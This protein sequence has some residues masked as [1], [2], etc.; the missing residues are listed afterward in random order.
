MKDSTREKRVFSIKNFKILIFLCECTPAKVFVF[1]LYLSNRVCLLFVLYLSYICLI[2]SPPHFPAPR[3]T[4][5]PSF[6]PRLV[7]WFPRATC[8]ELRDH[9][10]RQQLQDRFR[11]SRRYLP[12]LLP[13]P[14]FWSCSESAYFPSI[15]PSPQPPP[16]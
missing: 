15:P 13:Y 14:P 9:F 16:P 2:G 6:P 8:K 4:Y 12:P 3:M 5:Y 10:W 1:V 11:G 7:K